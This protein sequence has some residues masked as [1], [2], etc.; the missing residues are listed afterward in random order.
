MRTATGA[1]LPYRCA[2]SAALALACSDITT[3]PVTKDVC[4]SEL[5][6]VGGKRGS[7]EMYPGRDCVG[8]HLDN[9]GPELVLGGTVYAYLITDRELHAELQ[10]GKDCFGLEGVTVR[11]E[12]DAGQMFELTTNRA[13]NFFVEGNP[14]DFAKPFR[15]EVLMG[16]I[17]R[18]MGTS[19][20]YGGCARCHDPAAPSA[21]E[22]GLA[23]TVEP[24]DADY[25]NGTGR[26]GVP[27]YRP[28]GPDAPTVEQELLD[29]AGIE[30]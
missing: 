4:H 19:P 29:I 3:E 27:D 28:G 5:R 15:A 30:P 21:M 11:I 14:R 24:A 7:E 8:C 16:D 17:Q 18:G 20:Q 9:D 26:I 10:T 22:L 6:W 12:D 23:F 25:R 1:S 2:G 13:G